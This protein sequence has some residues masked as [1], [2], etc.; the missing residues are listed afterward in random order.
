VSGSVE[1]IRRILVVVLRV[2]DPSKALTR[3]HVKKS[4]DD[5]DMVD[6]DGGVGVKIES[7]ESARPAS[8]AAGSKP[9]PKSGLGHL[10]G[11]IP[12]RGDFDTE[13]ENDAELTLADMEFKE[14]DTKWE[15]D[16][17]LKVLEI[18]NSK[19]DAR[20]ERKKFIL[21]RGLLER[22]EKKRSKEEREVYNNM[23]VFA[24]F[25]SAEEHEAFIQGLLSQS[26]RTCESGADVIARGCAC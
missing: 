13:W 5:T 6:V 10:V 14:E 19:L 15:R 2:Q 22:K 11:Y 4:A 12:N 16:L 17:K 24:R 3:R 23:R 9:K 25:H 21:E 1:L 20:I 18:Y 7:K 26:T 8:A